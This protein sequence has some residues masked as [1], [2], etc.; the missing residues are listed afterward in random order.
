[1]VVMFFCVLSSEIYYVSKLFWNLEVNLA[2]LKTKDLENTDV[3]EK[4]L[5][6]SP[7]KK[8]EA[9]LIYKL[10]WTKDCFFGL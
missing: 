8:V 6:S 4:I 1:M 7:I 5:V 3:L 10:S 2:S 9:L